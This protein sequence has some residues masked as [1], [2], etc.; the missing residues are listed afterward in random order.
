[1]SGT[2]A[3]PPIR[4]AEAELTSLDSA[5]AGLAT[6]W[7]GGAGLVFVLVII[8]S[9]MGRYGN[10]TQGAWEWLLPTVMPTLGMIV[11]GLGYTATDPMRSAS[12]VR[13]TFYRLSYWLSAFYLGLILLTL[14]LQP[15]TGVPPIDLMHTSNLW[16]GPIQGLVASALGALFVSKQQKKSDSS[17][18]STKTTG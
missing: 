17:A 8:Q 16:L 7:F 13:K 18:D 2:P 5:R 14:L 3:D 4:M 11:A 10:Q 12:V 15:F 1:M 9:L 6:L